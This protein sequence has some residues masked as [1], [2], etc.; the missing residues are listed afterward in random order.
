MGNILN[1]KQKAYEATRAKHREDN[2]V[3]TGKGFTMLKDLREMSMEDR[4]K[5]ATLEQWEAHP[6]LFDGQENGD[7]SSATDQENTDP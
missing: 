3:P 6:E 4:L 2:P 7:G 5:F 1:D